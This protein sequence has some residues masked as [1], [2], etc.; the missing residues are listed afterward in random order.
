M[1]CVLGIE[2]DPLKSFTYPTKKVDHF[3]QTTHV[4]ARV[5]GGNHLQV[6]LHHAL[7][8]P[9]PYVHWPLQSLSCTA[10]SMYI[11]HDAPKSLWIEY[12]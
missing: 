2:N 12:F 4:D 6:V 10:S 5:I 8:E 1:T 7:L 9:A 3:G 11:S